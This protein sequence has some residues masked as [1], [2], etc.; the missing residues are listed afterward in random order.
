MKRKTLVLLI[1]PVS[2]ILTFSAIFY[3]IYNQ[4]HTNYAK[5]RPD[6]RLESPAQLYQEFLENEATAS[7]RYNGKMIEFIGTP[8]TFEELDGKTIAVFNVED[9]DFG[10]QGVRCTFIAQIPEAN[11][12][13]KIRL[14]GFLTGFNDIDVILENCSL[15][16]E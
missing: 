12:Q 9:G 14:K 4:P 10:P 15:I 2:A 5:A 6:Y 7:A 11:K 1:I 8:D 13:G 16:T 3:Y